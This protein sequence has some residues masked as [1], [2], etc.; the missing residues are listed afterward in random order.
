MKG[1]GRLDDGLDLADGEGTS[2]TCGR[3][4]AMI[5]VYDSDFATCSTPRQVE[6]H[7][8]LNSAERGEF[9]GS[10]LAGCWN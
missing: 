2:G 4:N 1:G 3:W 10:G 7:R 5:F 8:R 6:L 9:C